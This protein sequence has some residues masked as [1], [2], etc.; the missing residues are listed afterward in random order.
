[1]SKAGEGGDTINGIQVTCKPEFTVSSLDSSAI[2][3]FSEKSSSVV[4]F[5]Y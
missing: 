1:M 5:L 4:S 3:I 2:I